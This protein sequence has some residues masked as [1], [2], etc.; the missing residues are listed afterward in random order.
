VSFDVSQAIALGGA[1]GL[2]LLFRFPF[3][4]FNSL[5]ESVS[6]RA[7]ATAYFYGMGRF[8]YPETRLF[9]RWHIIETVDLVV[10]VRGFYPMFHLWD[11]MSQSFFD[12]FMLSV[13]LGFGVKLAPAAATAK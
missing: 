7:P 6:G 12:Q 9:L 8:F 10:N 1:I 13:G 3:E 11:G 4:F 5:P 2:D